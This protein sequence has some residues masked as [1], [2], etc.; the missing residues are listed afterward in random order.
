[1]DY[2][3]RNNNGD[4]T[5]SAARLERICQVIA[6]TCTKM[7]KYSQEGHLPEEDYF[8]FDEDQ[9]DEKEETAVLL[10]E[11]PRWDVYYLDQRYSIPCFTGNLISC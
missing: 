6:K 11:I 5:E 3:R 1:M 9:L 4:E 7:Q 8:Y 10:C 2:L